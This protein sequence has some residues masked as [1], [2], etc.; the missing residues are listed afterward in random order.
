MENHGKKL[1]ELLAQEKLRPE[2]QR[3]TMEQIAKK[4]GKTRSWLFK[5]QDLKQFTPTQ[6]AS[7]GRVYDT[8]LILGEKKVLEPTDQAL[9]SKLQQ[10]VRDLE[11]IVNGDAKNEGIEDMLSILN[12]KINVMSENQQI[13][14]R[15]LKKAGIEVVI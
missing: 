3:R 11:L 14:V 6:L 7:V 9:I 13:L 8:K 1:R 2:S 4:M 15:K 10:R 5:L 12:S